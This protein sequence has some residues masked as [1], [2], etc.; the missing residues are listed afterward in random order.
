MLAR[1][2]KQTASRNQ[3][4]HAAQKS[5]YPKGPKDPNMELCRVSIFAIVIVVLGTHLLLGSLDP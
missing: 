1:G 3:K 2:A 4:Y 5:M